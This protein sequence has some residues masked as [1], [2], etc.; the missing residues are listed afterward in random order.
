MAVQVR[1]TVLKTS[2][3]SRAESKAVRSWMT[4]HPEVIPQTV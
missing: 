1:L 3:I 4:A 2:Q